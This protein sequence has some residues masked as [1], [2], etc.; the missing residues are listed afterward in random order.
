M[1]PIILTEH[2]D[3]WKEWCF[4]EERLLKTILPQIENKPKTRENQMIFTGFWSRQ[5]DLPTRPYGPNHARY[6]LRYAS[7]FQV[8]LFRLKKERK[9][10]LFGSTYVLFGAAGRT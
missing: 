5:R 2:Q 6:Q 1:F 3:C 9:S 10:N 8:F 4:E 7:I